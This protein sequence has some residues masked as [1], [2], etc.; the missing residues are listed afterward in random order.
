SRELTGVARPTRPPIGRDSSVLFEFGSDFVTYQATNLL[1]RFAANADRI[2]AA[3][4]AVV[5]AR[6]AT[7]L[8]NGAIVTEPV[9]LA[10]SR[11]TRVAEILRRM[12]KAPVSASW[13][14]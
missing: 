5:G 6:G 14:D 10:Q 11:A 3:G 7:Q 4:I 2:G 12:Q 9:G 13:S 8:S 1:E